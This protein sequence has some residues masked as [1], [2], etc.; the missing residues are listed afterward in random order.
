MNDSAAKKETA[1]TKKAREKREHQELLKRRNEQLSE[2]LEALHMLKENLRGTNAA[3]KECDALSSHSKG[4]Y[5]EINK[6]AKGK[7]LIPVTDLAVT[8]ANDIIQDAKTI[9]RK[10][11]HLD[12]IRQF[13][14]AGDN[15][16]YPDVVVVIRSVRDSVER[17]EEELAKKRDAIRA[18]TEKAR[19][20]IGALEYFLDE[21]TEEA[22]DENRNY[23]SKSA[24]EPYVEGRITDSCFSKFTDSYD[25]YFDFDRLDRQTLKE[26]L[27][28][29]HCDEEEQEDGDETELV[30]EAEEE[31]QEEDEQE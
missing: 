22:E 19:T 7:L 24:I 10:D 12:R 26:Y 5:E 2:A 27:S 11:V 8:Q 13:V 28:T 29:E 14:P 25:K 18:Q 16:V 3:I 23:P 20:L 15:P 21:D 17:F 1:E 9:V 30:D 6:L 4:F 31:E